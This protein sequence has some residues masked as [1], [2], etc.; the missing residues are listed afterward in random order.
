MRPTLEVTV[1]Q[2]TPVS[3][4]DEGNPD[5]QMDARTFFDIPA[6]D[7]PI[8][9]DADNTDPSQSERAGSVTMKADV[10]F[11]LKLE[12]PSLY[13]KL[14]YTFDSV[15][16]TDRAHASDKSNTPNVYKAGERKFWADNLD[17]DGNPLSGVK[18]YEISSV[19]ASNT[20]SLSTASI[21]FFAPNASGTYDKD[22][23]FNSN[24]VI[25][26]RYVRMRVFAVSPA[27]GKNRDAYIADFVFTLDEIPASSN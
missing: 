26:A 7:A 10:S 8:A 14:Y 24:Y 12:N 3:L 16:T 27:D 5:P 22:G 15:Q 1:G 17:A 2:G 9:Y 18:I 20:M 19:A 25:D 4:S 11:V 13:D 6:T 21:P 23:V